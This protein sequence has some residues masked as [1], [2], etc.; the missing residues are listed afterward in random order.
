MLGGYVLRAI[1][2]PDMINLIW[3]NG[4]S[5]QSTPDMINPNVS[6]K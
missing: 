2:R 5:M 6:N 1:L 3:K 4:Y